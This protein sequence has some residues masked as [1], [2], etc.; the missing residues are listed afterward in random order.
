MLKAFSQ[1]VWGLNKLP[2][3]REN[4]NFFASFIGHLYV[5]SCIKAVRGSLNANFY[6]QN[7]YKYVC[8]G[9]ENIY[10]LF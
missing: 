7:K 6:N 3:P 4:I 2:F 9:R 5:Q 8:Y 10:S 1:I